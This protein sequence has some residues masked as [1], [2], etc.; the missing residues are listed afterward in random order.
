MSTQIGRRPIPRRRVAADGLGIVAFLAAVFAAGEA[1][2]HP[3]TQASDH[4]EAQ[5][6]GSDP[7]DELVCPDPQPREGQRR[8]PDIEATA[9]VRVTSNELFDCPEAY[10]GRK[11]V[12]RGEVV[13]ALLDRG[14]GV[15]SQ[16]NDDVYAELLGPLPAHRDYRGGNAGVGVLLPHGA[17]DLVSF[18]GGPQTRGDVLEVEG[19]FHRVDPTGEVAVIHA[20]AAER[21]ADGEPFPDPP[22]ADRRWAA[23]LAIIVALALVVTERVVAQR[24]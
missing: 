22:L 1:L 21:M 2:R 20:D 11:V 12:Y 14:V 5:I 10:D 16:L 15:W 23:W 9:P 18:I 7:R 4:P 6:D 3:Y 17:V 19:T 24:R 13:G 8:T